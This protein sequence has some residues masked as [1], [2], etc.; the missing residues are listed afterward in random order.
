MIPSDW[1]KSVSQ[2]YLKV[3][4]ALNIISFG[5]FE[6]IRLARRLPTDAPVSR[7]GTFSN[8]ALALRRAFGLCVM[9]RRLYV[10]I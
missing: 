2:M 4:V 3:L 5:A 9:N 1:T 7:G 10:L 8:Q 6:M